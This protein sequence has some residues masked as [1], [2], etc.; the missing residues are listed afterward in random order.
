[1]V[2]KKRLCIYRF[3]DLK[4]RKSSLYCII[5][6]WMVHTLAFGATRAARVLKKA[7]NCLY[8][9]YR[10]HLSVTFSSHG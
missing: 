9:F 8:Y 3:I 6:P 2:D 7:R 10:V 5:R 4:E 1:M